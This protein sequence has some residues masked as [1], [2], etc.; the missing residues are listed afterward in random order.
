MGEEGLFLFSLITLFW[1]PSSSIIQSSKNKVFHTNSSPKNK[2]K[3]TF[4]IEVLSNHPKCWNIQTQGFFPQKSADLNRQ[5]V[6]PYN[7]NKK[8]LPVLFVTAPSSRAWEQ[9]SVLTPVAKRWLQKALYLFPKC[10]HPS[11]SPVPSAA[12]PAFLQRCHPAARLACISWGSLFGLVKQS[13]RTL[14]HEGSWA[15]L[16][17]L[18][19]LTSE[20]KTLPPQLQMHHS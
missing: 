1:E 3:L 13:T 17:G 16:R 11:A 19:P 18:H 12:C 2:Y 5:M 10:C 9:R 8:P 4:D 14:R 20:I 6:L 7:P 15:Q